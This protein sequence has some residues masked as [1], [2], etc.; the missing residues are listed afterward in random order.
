M[1]FALYRVLRKRAG[2]HLTDYRRWV[3]VAAAAVGAAV[4][5]RALTWIAELQSR[6]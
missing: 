2:D 1:G 4:G 3:I 6:K 5:A